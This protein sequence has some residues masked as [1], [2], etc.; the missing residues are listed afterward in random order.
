MNLE[1][2][3]AE[4]RE[5]LV[6]SSAELWSDAELTDYLNDGQSVINQVAEW[7]EDLV[8]LPVSSAGNNPTEEPSTEVRRVRRVTY[9]GVFLPFIP[10][11]ELDRYKADWRDDSNDKPIRW[12]YLNDMPVA[13][14]LR[15]YPGV[16]TANVTEDYSFNQ[17]TGEA[18]R[19]V[20]DL[21]AWTFS[22]E[23]GIVVRVVDTTD[24]QFYFDKQVGLTADLNVDDKAIGLWFLQEPDELINNA[25][26]PQLPSWCH[27]SLVCFALY[28]AYDKEGAFRD[29][30]LASA[31]LQEFMD[32]LRVIARIRNR[33]FPDRVFSL[34]AIQTGKSFENR[35][36][37][38]E[39]A[40][41]SVTGW[42]RP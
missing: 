2:L 41:T 22:Q 13:A 31:Y 16:A 37:R 23:T 6:E 20:E 10:Q 26:S 8:N 33:Q 24:E 39:G 36:S 38:V 19:V 32:W 12:Y 9:D 30:Q 21:V 40:D 35:L 25:D 15:L 34:D 18:M 14:N 4:V 1:A 29:E 11:R 42:P 5:E 17:E 27:Q 3:L 28:R 7:R